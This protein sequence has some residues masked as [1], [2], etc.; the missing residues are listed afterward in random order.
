MN[1]F[2][3]LNYINHCWLNYQR[4]RS[5]FSFGEIEPQKHL[6]LQEVWYNPYPVTVSTLRPT[7]YSHKPSSK[8]PT[9]L[10]R[11][12]CSVARLKLHLAVGTQES[13]L[14]MA[15]AD[16]LTNQWGFL[17]TSMSRIII[18]KGT[19]TVSFFSPSLRP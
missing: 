17:V 1:L 19:V 15:S 6:F 18:Y 16:C 5:R 7:I 9:C 14:Q 4:K 12:P 2:V 3:F 13:V 10:L 11:S 8:P